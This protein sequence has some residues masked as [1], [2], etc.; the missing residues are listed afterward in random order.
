MAQSKQI[1]KALILFNG[2]ELNRLQCFFVSTL[3]QNQYFTKLAMN[4]ENTSY[5]Q[6]Y[7]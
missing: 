5:N 7:L 2:N 6:G 3:A 1:L 4:I